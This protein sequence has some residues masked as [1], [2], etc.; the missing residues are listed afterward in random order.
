MV[1]LEEEARWVLYELGEVARHTVDE[2]LREDRGE[3]R[4][5]RGHRRLRRRREQRSA[6][7]E[8]Q[9]EENLPVLVAAYALALSED[10][11]RAAWEQWRGQQ[12]VLKERIQEAWWSEREAPVR[13]R[14]LLQEY[15]AMVEPEQTVRWSGCGRGTN[16]WWRW[17][18]SGNARADVAI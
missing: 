11:L 2:R 17:W 4:S 8:P 16:D 12:Q 10:E 6:E 7:A 1:E 14:R 15:D 3:R 18:R 13:V 9:V 5:L